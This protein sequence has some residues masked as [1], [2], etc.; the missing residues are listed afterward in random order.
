MVDASPVYYGYIVMAAA[1][2]SFAMTLPGQTVGVS[3]FIDHII[4]ELGLSRSVVSIAYTVATV[5]AA[6]VLP[7][8]GRWVDRFGPRSTGMLA[9]AV[10]AAACFWMGFSNGLAW[11]FAGFFLLRAT[12]PG[13][14]SLVSLH[15]VNLW[16]VRK[17]GMA[18]GWLGVGLALATAVV[19][20]FIATAIETWGSRATYFAMGGVSAAVLLPVV[21]LFFRHQPEHYGLLPDGGDVTRAAG[22]RRERSTSLRGARKT[23]TFWIFT[24]GSFS[25]GAL[26]TGLL[27]HHFDIMQSLG[28]GR[29]EAAAMFVPFGFVTAGANLG[30][31]YLVDRVNPRFLLISGMGLFTVV[32]LGIP[33]MSTAMHVLAYGSLFGIVQGI[34]VALTGSV[35]AYY[36]GRAHLGAIKGFSKT[37]MVAGSA[38]GPIIY[39]AGF[40]LLGDYAVALV[41]TAAVPLAIAVLAL[42]GGR[43]ILGEPAR[44]ND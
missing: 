12:G 9:A 5:M 25:V 7:A 3:L 30:A 31:G 22:A 29:I 15:V 42:F 10:L 19:P 8:F 26:G 17:R 41:L 39:G 38:L 27:F 24:A 32:L 20:P 28:I 4:A 33:L 14:L 2:L 11:L 40:D 37:I 34:S 23:F 44:P 13:G 21:V 1:M 36:F 18:V 6:L 43:R 35:Y 16:W